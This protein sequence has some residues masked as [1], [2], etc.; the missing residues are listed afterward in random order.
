MHLGTEG[1]QDH[2]RQ[3]LKDEPLQNALPPPYQ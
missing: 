1:F 2:A 3:A